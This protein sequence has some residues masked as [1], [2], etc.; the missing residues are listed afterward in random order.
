MS[1]QK[2]TEHLETLPSAQKNVAS[3]MLLNKEKSIFMTAAELGYNAG[4]SEASA[5]RLA[6]TLG[7]ANFPDFI[8][9]L[10]QG[11][12]PAIALGRLQLHRC[13]PV[14]ADTFQY[15]SA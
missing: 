12:K 13:F 8:K 3:Y 2:I 5:I 14:R 7:Y 6:A 9:S 1:W 15:N 10:Q 11:T 4:S